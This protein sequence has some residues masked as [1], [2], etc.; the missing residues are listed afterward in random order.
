MSSSRKK[1]KILF[2][3]GPTASGK[4]ALAMSIAQKIGAEIVCADSQTLRRGIDLGTA[5]PSRE[6]RRLVEHHLVD[7]IEPDQSYSVAQFQKDAN[8]AIARIL[9]KNHIAIVVGGTGLYVDALYFNY[10]L[11][12]VPED[13]ELRKSLESKTVPELQAIILEKGYALPKN[14]KNPRH[15][16]RSIE[17][18]EGHPNNVTPREDAVIIGIECEPD[19]LKERI[20]QRLDEVFKKG[21][22]EE[23]AQLENGIMKGK[24]YDAIAC[25]ILSEYLRINDTNTPDVELLK[26]KIAQAEYQYTRRQRAWFKR[27]M[28]TK[29]FHDP[30]QAEMFAV[31]L[32][33]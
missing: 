26:Q 25:R 1:K 18:G 15:L 2:I 7:I 22:I 21:I 4:S 14:D 5:K 20:A 10:D 8:S 17:A 31:D 23:I 30:K 33:Q 28:Y 16:I 9:E 32:L 29:W 12:K 19:I 3:V 13:K 11:R 6:D 24:R 27:N